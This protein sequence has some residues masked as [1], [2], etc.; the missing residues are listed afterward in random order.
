MFRNWMQNDE[1]ID[2]TNARNVSYTLGHNQFSGMNEE[3][4]SVY[5]GYS[6]SLET[7]RENIKNKIK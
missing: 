4:F 5:L 7:R 1:Y 3:E 6:T 2:E